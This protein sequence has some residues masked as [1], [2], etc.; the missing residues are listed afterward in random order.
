VLVHNANCDFVDLFHGSRTGIVGG[1]L[2]LAEALRHRTS[3]HMTSR[4]PAVFFTDDLTR[5]IQ[6]YGRGGEIAR[7][8]VPRAMAERLRGLDRFG[9]RE[10]KVTSQADLDVMNQSIEILKWKDAFRFW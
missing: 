10:F 5:A 3:T 8:R 7:V 9:R 4:D 2:D 6:Q 1:K